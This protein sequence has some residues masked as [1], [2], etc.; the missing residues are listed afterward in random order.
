MFKISLVTVG[1]T[2]IALRK[3][4]GVATEAP[5]VLN[6]MV[7]VETEKLTYEGETDWLKNNVVSV[8]LFSIAGVLLIVIIILLLI[9][10]SEET[11]ED[12]DARALRTKRVKDTK[13][14]KSE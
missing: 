12:L 10:P 9:K 13:K 6:R 5:F 1:Y 2:F 7:V 14:K 8:I 11:L 4:F 3:L